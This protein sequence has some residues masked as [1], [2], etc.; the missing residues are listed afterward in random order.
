MLI[1]APSG[2]VNDPIDDLTPSL[3][4]T[5]SRVIGMVALLEEVL[6]AKTARD[7][8]F[9]KNLKGLSLPKTDKRLP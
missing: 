4:L 9:I 3:F 8:T 2:T 6:N 1:V 5:V 7:L